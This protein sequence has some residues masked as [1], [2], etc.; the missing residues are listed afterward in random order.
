MAPKKNF[1]GHGKHK[2]I[3]PTSYLPEGSKRI[4]KEDGTRV[5]LINGR[6]YV[7][8]AEYFQYL[9][10]LQMVKNAEAKKKTVVKPVEKHTETNLPEGHNGSSLECTHPFCVSER[11]ATQDKEKV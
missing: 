10:D 1:N 8:K 11:E 3:I 4:T 7:S 5:W 2:R 6:E 9:Q